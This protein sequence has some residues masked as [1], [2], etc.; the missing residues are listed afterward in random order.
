MKYALLTCAAILWAGLL[1]AQPAYTFH[2]NAF[3]VLLYDSE[4][5]F[6]NDSEMDLH[7]LILFNG[8]PIDP[9]VFTPYLFGA[10]GNLPFAPGVYGVYLEGWDNWFPDSVTFQDIT[11]DYEVDFLGMQPPANY[12]L[13]YFD[14]QV[15]GGNQVSLSWQTEYESN[16]LGYRIY[17]NL[18]DDLP[19]AV[20]I[21]PMIPAT[22]TGQPANYQ[23]TDEDP[24]L[25]QTN[26]YWLEAIELDGSSFHGPVSVYVSG[27]EIAP[28]TGIPAAESSRIHSAWP[29]PI[30]TDST[31]TIAVWVKQGETGSLGIY[32]LHGQELKRFELGPGT[33][34]LAW[35]GKDR[36]GSPCGSGT[37]L[38]RLDTP[39]HSDT[40][41]LVIIK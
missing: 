7:A 16:L 28:E 36:H 41:K 30:R 14:A 17:H 24:A 21:G 1:C 26:F 29:N 11:I 4:N 38:I 32:N 18:S 22:N 20:W 34:E 6:P 31:A 3:D 27:T 33:H 19:S 10:P 40:R 5:P 13:N 15:S 2:I 8:A 35:N 37:Y 25:N 23:F 39:S 12:L 9:P